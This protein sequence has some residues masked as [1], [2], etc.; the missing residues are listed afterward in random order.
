MKIDQAYI[1]FQQ[2]INKNLT[3]DNLS[4]DKPR[5]I[6]IFNRVQNT[7]V[8]W[9]LEKSNQDDVRDIQKL[10][11]LNKKL[12]KSSEDKITTGFKLPDNYFNFSNLS[13]TASAG[14]CKNEKILVHEI[15]VQDVEELL[16]DEFQKPS[17]EF[18]ETFYTVSSDDMK[19]YTNGFKIDKALLSYYRYPLQVDISGY[20]KQD[21]T[22]SSDIDPEFDDKVVNKILLA[23][24]KDYSYNAGDVNKYQLD[25]ERI[26]S[27]I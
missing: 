3:N 18:R 21:N 16:N 13:I 5:F 20:V 4:V 24:S 7:Y 26:F 25:K 17:F 15:K 9:L 14:N 11:V 23:C 6:N 27:E 8:E 2:L 19:V 12:T 22:S 10:L 1:T